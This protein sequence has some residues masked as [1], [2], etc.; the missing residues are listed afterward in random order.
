MGRPYREVRLSDSSMIREFSRDV[1]IHELEWH[2]DRRDRVV[3]VIE[4]RGWKLQLQ[5]GLPFE[6]TP[7][8]SYM[9]P[10]ESWHRVL[11]G[12]GRLIILLRES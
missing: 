10:R 6:L 4:G 11:R 9:I 2:M 8:R 1:P 5:E 3:E 7:G 12:S